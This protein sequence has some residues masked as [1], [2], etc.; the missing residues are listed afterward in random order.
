M[1]IRVMSL[2][3]QRHKRIPWNFDLR[4]LYPDHGPD[5]L[6]N[7]LR[8]NHDFDKAVHEV[9]IAAGFSLLGHR[10]YWVPTASDR[11]P[12][13]AVL[14]PG[15][16][17]V[18]V[19]C[20]K[21]DAVGGVG[22]AADRLWLTFTDL[23]NRAMTPAKLNYCLTVTSGQFNS[24]DAQALVAEIVLNLRGQSDGSFESAVGPYRVD[25]V[26]LCAAGEK[27]DAEVVDIFPRGTFGVNSGDR[28]RDLVSS[29]PDADPRLMGPITDPKMI[30]LEVIDDAGQKS[31]TDL[32]LLKDA[33][34]QVGDATPSVTFLDVNL[35]NYET[36]MDEYDGIL[37][38]VTNEVINGRS[39]ASATVLVNY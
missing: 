19:E 34:D 17:P 24:G 18:A 20:K 3:L 1:L 33:S 12:E 31:K 8:S 32:R 7:R 9:R 26:C 5:N 29:A 23:M 14:I 21:R 22:I 4:A 6:M 16:R 35:S 2:A 28:R 37:E 25:F 15:D 13:F 36:E 39:N 38:S 27:I 10:I 11:T 30:R